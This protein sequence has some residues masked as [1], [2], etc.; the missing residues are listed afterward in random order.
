MEKNIAYQVSPADMTTIEDLL[1]S[2]SCLAMKAT[3]KKLTLKTGYAC[4]A[5]LVENKADSNDKYIYTFD[6]R[7]NSFM[8][9]LQE[10]V[11]AVQEYLEVRERE[12]Y[13]EE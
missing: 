7:P 12:A 5:I 13:C 6:S 11:N 10:A 1:N 4:E 3:G 8:D 2:F 9:I